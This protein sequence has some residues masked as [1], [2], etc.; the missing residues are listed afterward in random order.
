MSS[1][2]QAPPPSINIGGP[3]QGG[4]AG[5]PPSAIGAGNDP[6]AQQVTGLLRKA[7]SALTQAAQLEKDDIDASAISKLAA[8]VH[9]QI[10]AEQKLT[11]D[12]MGAGPGAKMI[13]KTAPGPGPAGA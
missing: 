5:G 9:S 7:F 13:R 2:I 4:P 6:D 3:A 8:Q 10:A 11:D 12:V 1:M